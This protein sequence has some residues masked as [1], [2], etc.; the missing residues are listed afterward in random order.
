MT[1]PFCIVGLGEAVFDIFPDKAVLGGT[2]L[3]LAVHAHQLL[4]PLDGC[5]VLL[6]RIGDDELGRRLLA[7][8][9]SRQL[10]TEHLQIDP[11]KPTGQVIVHFRNGA[12][13]YEI[14]VD[15]AWD[16]LDCG[17]RELEL[18][19]TCHAVSFGSMSQRHPTARAATARFLEAA[20]QALRL[21]DVNLRMDLYS[22]DVLAEGCR[23]ASLMKLN[24]DELPVV[25]RLLGVEGRDAETQAAGLRQRFDLEAVIHTRGPRGTVAHT[26]DGRIEREPV[27][28]PPATGADSVGAGDACSAGLLAGHL[29][30]LQWP[31]IIDLAN[32]L[33][34]YVASQP[35]ATPPLPVEL[36]TSLRKLIEHGRP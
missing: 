11:A 17:P 15:T 20:P 4:A 6:S 12:P 3:N 16:N 26:R 13:E 36:H 8:F 27:H 23:C 30:G 2:S 34:A 18:A 21:F 22:A 10:P 7:E 28:Y 25:A 5:G 32:H 29:S 35:S 24:E 19:R 1:A 14:V 33:G 31:A 9:H